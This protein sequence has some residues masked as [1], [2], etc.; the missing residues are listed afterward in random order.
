MFWTNKRDAI[1]RRLYKAFLLSIIIFIKKPDPNR[2]ARNRE[3]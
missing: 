2:I 1:N 3:T